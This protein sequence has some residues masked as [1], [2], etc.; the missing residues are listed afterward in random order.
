MNLLVGYL[1]Q[2]SYLVTFTTVRSYFIQSWW[3]N[4]WFNSN[5]IVY[6]TWYT[7]ALS[8]AFL[9]LARCDRRDIMFPG[10]PSVLLSV[11]PSVR[12]SHF[13]GTTLRAV[14][15]KNYAFST[16]YHACIAMPTWRRC[17]PPIY[18][19]V[20]IYIFFLFFFFFFRRQ[21]FRM[22][23]FDCQAGPLQNFNRSHVMVIGRSVLFSDPARPPGG[24]VGRPKHPKIPPSEKKIFACVSEPQEHF[25]QNL[26]GK[27]NPN[28]FFF[29]SVLRPQEDV[30][31]EKNKFSY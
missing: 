17:A 19:F 28:I 31:C 2:L 18:G 24:G 10:C 15:S 5:L 20:R 21:G 12:P 6:Q 30:F 4:I 1:R 9:C 13:R 7:G 25:W 11:R 16:N 26:V 27:K 22:I 29:F 14:P 3:A 23:T 8:V